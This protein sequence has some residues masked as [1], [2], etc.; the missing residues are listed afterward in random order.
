MSWVL[1]YE[2]DEEGEDVP[3]VYCEE[4]RTKVFTKQQMSILSNELIEELCNKH[5]EVLQL[6]HKWFW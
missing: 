6:Y 3:C 1:T 2:K 5:N 4:T